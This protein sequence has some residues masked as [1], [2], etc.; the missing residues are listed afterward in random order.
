MPLSAIEVG[1]RVALDCR[2]AGGANVGAF[3]H[4]KITSRLVE[5]LKP[6]ETTADTDLPG[7]G[8]RRQQGARIY[9]VRKHVKGRRH[10][11]TIGQHGREG[12]TEA[13]ARR[14]AL[15]IIASLRQGRDPAA[16]RA[17][18][19]GMPTL[20]SFA[21]D[22]ILQRSATLRPGTLSNYRSILNKHLAPQDDSGRLKSGCLG[23]ISLDQL[24]HTEVCVLHRALKHTPR[25]ANHV[26]DFL[27]SLFSE[28]KAAAIVPDGFNPTRRI[29]RFTIQA[30]QR[31]LSEQELARL[32]ET[33]TE[34]EKDGTESSFVIAAIRLL[35]FTGCR[36]NEILEARWEWVDFERGL[37][38]LPHS[39]T[40][41]KPVYLNAEAV[42]VLRTLPRLAENPYIIVGAKEG[43][44]LVNLRKAWVRI[45]TRAGLRPST[46]P[47]GELQNVRLHDLRHSYASLLAS[48]GASLPMIGKLLGHSQPQTTA[49][50]AHLTE[51]PLRR[52][53][54]QAGKSAKAIMAGRTKGARR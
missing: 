8:V 21:E 20:A 39:K 46:G 35:I 7:Y 29:K 48:G 1:T 40:G 11:V 49:R 22:F 15:L 36:R 45:R 12:W 27:G 38:L 26:L 34:I 14:E 33:L 37:L 10:Y 42:Q 18:A 43:Q 30:R 53:S 5:A 52:L 51:D 32:G 6:G 13:K 54:D 16:D 28:A 4:A 24:G 31:F 3:R 17:R 19:R 2:S 50:Y 44:R 41:A 23:S 25:A 47:D 9:F